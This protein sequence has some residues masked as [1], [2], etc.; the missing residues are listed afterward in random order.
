V[1]AFQP[2]A[3]PTARAGSSGLKF[4]RTIARPGKGMEL[5]LVSGR[6]A[7]KPVEFEGNETDSLYQWSKLRS[8]YRAEANLSSAQMIVVD[9]PAWW[10]GA[11]WHWN[12]W[13]ST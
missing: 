8:D 12:F 1:I 11:G 5:P 4:G 13:Y 7:L 3:P 2:F 10:Y 6:C 9:H